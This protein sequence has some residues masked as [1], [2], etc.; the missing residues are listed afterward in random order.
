[1]ATVRHL[2]LF[3]QGCPLT[4]IDSISS[5]F[6]DIW[7]PEQYA[8][9]A[10]WRVKKWRFNF[11]ASWAEAV[12]GSGITF[13]YS[14][15]LE[16]NYGQAILDVEDEV[17]S[18]IFGQALENE[19]ELVCP[20]VIDAFINNFGG[21]GA[22]AQQRVA[23]PGSSGTSF[24]GII[25]GIQSPYVRVVGD[26]K[27]YR[28][29][30]LFRAETLRWVMSAANMGSSFPVAQ[31][32]TFAYN[33]LGQAFECPIYAY[34]T[35]GSTILSVASSLE[36]IEYWPYDP[37]DGGGPIYDSTTGQQLREFPA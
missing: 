16:F 31:Y 3:P 30:I 2:G 28:L 18:G 33:L 25:N 6:P 5:D 17:Y 36:A 32:G 23:G 35:R 29:R 24:D 12:D 10:H 34:N 26:L 9:A 21:F 13:A 4:T 19:T 20:L 27:E 14:T 1:M 8:L 22:R 11:V 7:L 37:N 15:S